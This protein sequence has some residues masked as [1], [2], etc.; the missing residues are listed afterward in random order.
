MPPVAESE[1]CF[2]IM[3]KPAASPKQ[4]NWLLAQSR[5]WHKW[6]G[7]IAGLFLLSVGATGMV[8]N[9]KQPIFSSLGIELKRDRDAS[10]L[11]KA[12]PAGEVTLTTGAGVAG[13]TVSFEQALAIA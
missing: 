12:K 10:P 2:R 9:Y 11:P 7:L 4:K 5:Q 13:G 8:L 3:Q 6:G 1:T